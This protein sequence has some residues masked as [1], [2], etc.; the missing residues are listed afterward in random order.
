MIWVKRVSSIEREVG[1]TIPK[2]PKKD[3]PMRLTRDSQPYLS[4]YWTPSK[5]LLSTLLGGLLRCSNKA[6]FTTM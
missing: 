6:N 3:E 4:T 5:K 1:L 2:Q